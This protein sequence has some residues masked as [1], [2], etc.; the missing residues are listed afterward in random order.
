MYVYLKFSFFYLFLHPL[1]LVINLSVTI[2]IILYCLA[3]SRLSLYLLSVPKNLYCIC[4]SIPQIYTQ[5]DAVQISSKFWDTQYRCLSDPKLNTLPVSPLK[6]VESEWDLRGSLVD[7]LMAPVIL[8]IART[9][10]HV[11]DLNKRRVQN[12]RQGVKFKKSELPPW[13][14]FE[15]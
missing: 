6:Q 1:F 13:Q 7:L 11:R 5:A 9:Q 3:T 8:V 14:P 15:I 4:L 10:R 12:F 2:C